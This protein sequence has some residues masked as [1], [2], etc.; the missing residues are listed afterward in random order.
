MTR[1][2]PKPEADMETARAAVLLPLPLK[3]AY[4]YALGCGSV[5]RGTLVVAPLGGRETL[6]VVWGDAEGGVDVAKLKEATP[7]EGYPRLPVSRCDCVDWVARYTLS[8][9]GM[10]LSL[11]LRSTSAFSAEIPRIAYVKG[12]SA[13][14]RPTPSR[15][16]VL[17][18]VGDGLA[19]SIAAIAEESGVSPAVVRGL[20]EC[21]ALAETKLPEFAPLRAPEPDFVSAE[22][23]SEQRK[24]ADIL[25][26]AVSA[27]RFF[28]NLL[29]GVTGS[30]KTETYFE[31]IA[32]ALRQGKQTLVLLP[33]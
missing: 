18:V 24:A 31:A 10:V 14:H 9:P 21:G 2:A 30:G 7:L 13:P 17:E 12:D 16:R 23:N 27:Q 6:G 11:A 32:E 8:P 22:L 4:D 1:P 25:V 20:I 15:Q 28:A 26:R 3:G 5:P 19:R 33:E 29:D